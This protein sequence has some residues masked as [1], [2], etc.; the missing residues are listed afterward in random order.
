MKKTIAILILSVVALAAT[1]A[2]DFASLNKSAG[3][4]LIFDSYSV[5]EGNT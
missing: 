1:F 5:K 4:G 2:L 3:G